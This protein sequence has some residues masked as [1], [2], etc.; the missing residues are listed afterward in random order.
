ME[1]TRDYRFR[2]YP[3]AGRQPGIN[4][5]TCLSKEPYNR[6]PEKPIKPCKGGNKKLSMALSYRLAKGPRISKRHMQT[7]SRTG[8][9]IKYRVAVPGEPGSGNT[10][11]AGCG[12]CITHWS[13]TA[14]GRGRMSLLAAHP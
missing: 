14:S 10:S 3:D 8:S 12:D 7:H 11:P 5:Q 9:E 6:L 2:V 4:L 1:P 13:P